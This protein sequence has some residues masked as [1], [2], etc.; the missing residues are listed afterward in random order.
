MRV[1]LVGDSHLTE[2]SPRRAVRKLEPRLR[3]A[4]LDVACDEA[5]R[6]CWDEWADDG[7]HAGELRVECFD[8]TC[9]FTQR[10]LGGTRRRGRIAGAQV[11]GAG[12]ELADRE[13]AELFTDF[14][15]GGDDERSHLVERAGAI[16]CGRA[17]HQAQRPHRFDTAGAQSGKTLQMGLG[18]A[19]LLAG[20]G[21]TFVLAGVGLVW[22]GRAGVTLKS[23][24][25]PT[26]C[27]TPWSGHTGS[28]TSRTELDRRVVPGYASAAEPPSR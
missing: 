3:L 10:E 27:P 6:G 14:V 16:T 7:V 18:L 23:S 9:E 15:G 19:A 28:T 24:T 4:G 22:A 5:G 13:T 12:D 26:P 8:A 17:S 20:L 2:T 21:A 11:G 25:F 1:A